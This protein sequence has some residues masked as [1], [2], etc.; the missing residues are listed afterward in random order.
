MAGIAIR[1]GDKLSLKDVRAKGKETNKQA[2][3][4]LQTR[5]KG[6]VEEKMLKFKAKLDREETCFTQGPS[7]GLNNSSSKKS[8]K[9][10]TGGKI[11]GIPDMDH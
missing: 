8:K 9:L 2:N 11:P 5:K 4:L 6:R 3:R 7:G 1:A 10:P